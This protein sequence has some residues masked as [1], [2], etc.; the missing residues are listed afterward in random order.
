M[1]EERYSF[2]LSSVKAK[3]VNTMAM[4]IQ[5]PHFVKMTN[6]RYVRITE[7]RNK[8]FPGTILDSR[9]KVAGTTRLPCPVA[10]T[11]ASTVTWKRKHRTKA[12][13]QLIQEGR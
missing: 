4:S 2:L 9:R 13:I 12:R 11:R 1:R 5:K 3:S 7:N 6:V 10:F 8:V